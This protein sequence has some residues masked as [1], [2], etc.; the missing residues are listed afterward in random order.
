MK[1]ILS[2][3]L[4]IC[5]AILTS[6]THKSYAF[7]YTSCN[8]RCYNAKQDVGG[9]WQDGICTYNANPEWGTPAGSFS[10][11]DATQNS[12]QVITRIS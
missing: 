7:G 12:K 10:C 1:K 2:L 11:T 9:S 3:T 8:M 4:I 5:C 6:T